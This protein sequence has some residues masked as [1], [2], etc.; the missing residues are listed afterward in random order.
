MGPGDERARL[1]AARLGGDLTPG[2]RLARRQELKPIELDTSGSAMDNVLVEKNRD[3]PSDVDLVFGRGGTVFRIRFTPGDR[4]VVI[5]ALAAGLLRGWSLM[6]AAGLGPGRADAW[7]LERV[8]A[9]LQGG[10][11]PSA[12][13]LARDFLVGT[14]DEAR[15]TE[16]PACGEIGPGPDV[17]ALERVIALLEEK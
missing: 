9:R 15:R 17:R 6:D 1:H 7:A 3:Y 13:D 5:A 16:Q 10:V 14:L 11:L 12:G 4:A 8:I 2:E